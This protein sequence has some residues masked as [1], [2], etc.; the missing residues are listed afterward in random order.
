VTSTVAPELP[1]DP[2]LE[3]RALVQATARRT[4]GRRTLTSRLMLGLC[5]LAM[6]LAIAPLV[7]VLVELIKRGLQWWSVTFFTQPPAIPSIFHPNNIGGIANAIVGSLVIDAF[8]VAIAVP[9]GVIAGLLLSE[10]DNF[11]VNSLRSTAEVMTG[12]PSILLGV[13]AYEFIV[14]KLH[15]GFS[16]IAGSVALA[17]LMIPVIMKASE[18]ALRTVP[19]HLKEAGLALGCRQSVVSRRIIVPSALPGL[20]TAVLLA[21]ARAVGETAPLLWV[22][23]SSMAITW[24][25]L[26]PMA[27]LPLSIYQPFLNTPY[28]AQRDQAWGT[29]LFLVVVVLVLNLGSRLVAAFI[30]R[31]RR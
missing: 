25:P 10:S 20:I 3:R 21:T 9:L 30:Q 11:F 26:K 27:A 17:V 2:I 19:G 22:I 6:A 14:I 7:W 16:G 12:L 1:A 4:L 29:A 13:F 18:T 28:P 5:G 8:A 23:G 24:N 31:E 15:V